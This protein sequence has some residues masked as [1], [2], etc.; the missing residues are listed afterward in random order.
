VQQQTRNYA[1]RQYT[2][3]RNQPPADWPRY[4]ESLNHE[5]IDHLAIKLRKT[6]LT[7]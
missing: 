2:W 1:K 6:L 3:F 5:I 7:A 4:E